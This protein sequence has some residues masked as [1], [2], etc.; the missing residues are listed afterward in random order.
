MEQ[1]KQKIQINRHDILLG[2]KHNTEESFPFILLIDKEKPGVL[3]HKTPPNMAPHNNETK[4]FKRQQK[5]HR[6]LKNLV[7]WDRNRVC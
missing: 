7:N 3:C 1:Q 6:K 4:I 2:T 5:I